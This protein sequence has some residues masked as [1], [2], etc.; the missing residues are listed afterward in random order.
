MAHNLSTISSTPTTTKVF[1]NKMPKQAIFI[2]I[3]VAYMLFAMVK[4]ITKFTVG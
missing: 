3:K 1:V 4:C 2:G